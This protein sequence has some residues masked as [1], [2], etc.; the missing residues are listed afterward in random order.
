MELAK[1]RTEAGWVDP[2]AI[3]KQVNQAWA[4]GAKPKASETQLTETTAQEKQEKPGSPPGSV[5][6]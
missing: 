3:T 6:L 5:Q 4:S 1:K 2:A